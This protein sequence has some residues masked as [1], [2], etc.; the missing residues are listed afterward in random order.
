MQLVDVNHG[1]IDGKTALHV[2]AIT[3]NPD[4][5]QMLLDFGA[6]PRIRDMVHRTPTHWAAETGHHEVVTLLLEAGSTGFEKDADGKYPIHVATSRGHL[7]VVQSL[8]DFNSDMASTIDNVSCGFFRLS[9][10]SILS[11]LNRDS[12]QLFTLHVQ[13]G[14]KTLLG[15]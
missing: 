8:I 13:S 9:S 5:V 3:G 11:L 15:T 7:Q 6:N 14:E 2:A 1:D 12:E 4:S 10:D